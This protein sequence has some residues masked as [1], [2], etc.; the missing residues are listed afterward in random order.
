VGL[1]NVDESGLQLDGSNDFTVLAQALA[2]G[3][4][5]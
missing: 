3:R 4:D 2:G 5:S 1:S